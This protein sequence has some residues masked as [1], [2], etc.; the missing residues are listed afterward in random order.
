MFFSHLCYTFKVPPRWE[1]NSEST[2][3]VTGEMILFNPV[4]CSISG[5][6]SGSS[7]SANV[8]YICQYIFFVSNKWWVITFFFWPILFNSLRIWSGK[9]GTIGP[10]MYPNN[11][12]WSPTTILNITKFL[13]TSKYISS[14]DS[15]RE[16]QMLQFNIL[17]HISFWMSHRLKFKMSKNQLVIFPC[18]HTLYSLFYITIDGIKLCPV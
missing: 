2:I 9:R 6:V 16:L 8:S 7:L 12:L 10:P 17:L 11:S 14:S 15:L 3:C 1:T 5:V 13:L 18:K 4:R